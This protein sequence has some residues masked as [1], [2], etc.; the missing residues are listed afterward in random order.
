M[1]GTIRL[2]WPLR[3]TSTAM[4][5]LIEPGSTTC[6]LPSRSSKW[7]AIAGHSW[8]A[9]T[10]AQAIRWVKL[11]FIPRSLSTPFSALR[12]A[13]SVSTASV[14]NEVAVGIW[15]LSSIALASAPA[16]PRSDLG[17]AVGGASGAGGR[18][19]AVAAAGGQDVGLRDLAAGAGA[20]DGAQVDAFA[21][22][23][24]LRATGVACDV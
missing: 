20:L 8:P 14:R 10:I 1:H 17:L 7:R 6:G 19:G 16:G 22:A 3:S 23:A 21:A 11:T 18:R 15:R 9:L 12:L 13:S 2:R 24:A 5:R 4:P